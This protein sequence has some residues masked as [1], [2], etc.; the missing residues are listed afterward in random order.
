VSKQQEVE[1]TVA[2]ILKR[3]KT[4]D[5]FINNAG[6]WTDQEL[7]ATHPE[8][9]KQ[10]LEVNTLGTIHCTEA[11]LSHLQQ[12]NTGTILNIVSTAGVADIP[13]GNNQY[14]RTYGATK[15][16]VVGYSHALRWAVKDTKI[17]VMQFFPGG[18]D[19]DL[20]QNAG[21]PGSHA[22]PWMMKLSDVADAVVFMLTRPADV[23]VE[24]LVMS[25]M[26]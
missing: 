8:K 19:S 3:C 18:F 9:R 5:V 24:Q 23:Y 22:Q 16:G 13:A 4:I 17:K 15:W 11:V 25:K 7:E 21:R 6:I 26:V 2:A 12:K 10:A 1:K 14:W 20:Y